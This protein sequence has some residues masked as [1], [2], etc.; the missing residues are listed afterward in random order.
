MTKYSINEFVYNTAE[1]EDAGKE[2]FELENDYTLY[3]NLNGKVWVK[4]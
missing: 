3:V 2:L 1:K 4:L